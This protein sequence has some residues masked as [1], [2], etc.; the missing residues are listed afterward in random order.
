MAQNGNGEG[1]GSTAAAAVF[2]RGTVRGLLAGAAGVVVMTLVEKLEQ[3]FTGRPDSE[4]PARTLAR[5]IARDGTAGR[6]GRLNPVMHF[7][8]GVLLGSLP[9][10]MAQARLP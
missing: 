10:V 8:Q 9:R 6:R 4:V 5:G 3:R 2:R 1:E 7:R